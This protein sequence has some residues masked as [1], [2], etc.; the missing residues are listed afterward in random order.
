MGVWDIST[1]AGSDPKSQGDD[2]IRELKSALQEALRGGT[3]EGDL[4]IFP[5][6]APSTAPVF[7]YRGGKGATGARPAS[8]QSGIYFDTTRNALQRDNGSTWDDIG[9]LIPAGTVMCFFQAAAP[10]GWTQVTTQNDRV[11]RVVSSAGGGSGG[12]INTSTSLAHTH[13]VDSHTH[14]I[15]ASATSQTNSGNWYSQ[16]TQPGLT[17]SATNHNHDIPASTSGATSPGTD[18]KLGVL[19]YSDVILASKD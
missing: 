5:G 16:S 14:S 1:P 9:T 4:A 3:S 19:A 13:T 8:G 6:S 7:H 18:S 2:R 15:P 17:N 10:T 11:L 12:S